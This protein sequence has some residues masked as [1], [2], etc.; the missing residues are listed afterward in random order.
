MQNIKK[1]VTA[2]PTVEE[3]RSK[4]L[5]EYSPIAT[6]WADATDE[7]RDLCRY[8]RQMLGMDETHAVDFQKLKTPAEWNTQGIEGI[9]R[10][11]E[12]M[13]EAQRIEF[14][15]I[16]CWMWGQVASA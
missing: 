8:A 14:V 1:P 5:K 11:Y 10:F 16:H 9:I 4:L 15:A 12:Q 6:S 7:V 2:T 13:T 3:L